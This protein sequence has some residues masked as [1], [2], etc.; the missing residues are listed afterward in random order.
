MAIEVIANLALCFC[1]EAETPLVTDYA[2]ERTHC[3][4]AGVPDRAQLAGLF[5]QFIEALLAPGKVVE[6]FLGSLLHLCL[7][8]AGARDDRVALVEP[9][10]SN[11]SCVVYAHQSRGM[12]SLIGVEAAFFYV[13]R[14]IRARR[15]SCRSRDGPKRVANAG[16]N[17]VHGG[18]FSRLHRRDYT[19]DN[20][21]R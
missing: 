4:R 15:Q 6:L 14:R 2:T 18:Y 10:R 19:N 20:A 8:F 5:T 16:K 13:S 11:F 9:L 7:K 3:E 21:R 12:R 1:D 17:S